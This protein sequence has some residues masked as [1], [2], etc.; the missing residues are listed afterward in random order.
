MGDEN[1]E[2]LDKSVYNPSLMSDYRY[3]VELMKKI[4][5]FDVMLTMKYNKYC[6][7][8]IDEDNILHFLR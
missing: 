7:L 5:D 3:C 6:E 2:F 1:F 8:G 4:S